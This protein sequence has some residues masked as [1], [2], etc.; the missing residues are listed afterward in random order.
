MYT[1]TKSNYFDSFRIDARQSASHTGRPSLPSRV[2]E[3]L[4]IDFDEGFDRADD[5][6]SLRQSK[7]VFDRDYKP[8]KNYIKK[9]SSKSRET[10][11][12]EI[13]ANL[14]SS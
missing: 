1:T 10:M 3:L 13:Y 14:T 11:Y 8:Q 4:F 5:E 2:P 12:T 7:G 9:F 6:T